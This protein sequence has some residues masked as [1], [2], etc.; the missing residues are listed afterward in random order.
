VLFLLAPARRVFAII[1]VVAV[2]VGTLIYQ[3]GAESKSLIN[4]SYLPMP[5]AEALICIGV[6]LTIP[7]LCDSRTNAAISILR[8]P[9]LY[10]SSVSYTLYLVHYP[11]NSALERIFP[12]ASD[13]SW[14]AIGVFGTKVVMLMVAAHVFYLAFEANT[15]AV[16]RHL[17][18]RSMTIEERQLI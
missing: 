5:A 6:S 11:L 16:R 9:A 13:L 4:V 3:L 15:A 12:K 18:Q 10:L 2:I 1:G 8:R 14:T 17:K 7:F